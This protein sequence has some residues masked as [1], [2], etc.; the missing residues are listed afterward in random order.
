MRIG[1]I[2]SGSDRAIS[3]AGGQGHPDVSGVVLVDAD[4]ARTQQVAAELGA[5]VADTV[6]DL[7]LRSGRRDRGFTNGH[8][9][10]DG[11]QG[12]RGVAPDLL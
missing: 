1:V 6:D 11:A 10:G 12:G 3:R 2:R 9:R 8:P 7:L 4:R 5:D